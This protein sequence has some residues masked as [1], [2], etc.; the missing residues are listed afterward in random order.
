VKD[1]APGIDPMV[2]SKL[3]M[4]FVT[5][6]SSG[7]GLGLFISKSIVES[8]G[9][10]ISAFNNTNGKGATF[11]FTLPLLVSKRAQYAEENL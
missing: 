6:S 7:T 4:K 8:H 1:T 2:E 10:K 3:F 11:T 5:T 9:G